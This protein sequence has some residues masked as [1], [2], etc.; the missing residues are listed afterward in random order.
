MLF[1]NKS[2]PIFW[3]EVSAD[4]QKQLVS[5]AKRVSCFS[6]FAARARARRGRGLRLT[7]MERRPRIHT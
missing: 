4:Q 1:T 6:V 5:C 2:T 7:L 3:R